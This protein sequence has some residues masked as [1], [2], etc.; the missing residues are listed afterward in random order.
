MKKFKSFAAV[1]LFAV[2]LSA[3]ATMGYSVATRNAQL[4][5][6]TTAVG[7]AGTLTIYCGT[8]PATGGTATTVAATFTM[9]SPF[10]PG[11]S[12]AVLTP[13][14]PSAATAVATCTATWFRIATSGATQII[15][16]TVG[17]SGAD[18]NLTT[19]SITTGLS[20]SITSFTITR[21]NP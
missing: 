9:G 13:T 5:A 21:G 20:I 18:L 16:G 6:I 10:A 8:Q 19:T 1:A 7:N 17:T 2:C 14:L 4:N 11:A 3:Q 12:S 15:D